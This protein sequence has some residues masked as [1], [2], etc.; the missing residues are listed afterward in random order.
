[1]TQLTLSNARRGG[2]AGRM[3]L[4][5]WKEASEYTWID[6]Q[7]LENL[8]EVDKMLIETP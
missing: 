4:E 3:Q 6:K 7:H 8:S 2:E 5:D 1:M